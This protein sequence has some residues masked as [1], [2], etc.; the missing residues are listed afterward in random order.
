MANARVVRSS[1]FL[2]KVFYRIDPDPL[3]SSDVDPNYLFK[4][5]SGLYSDDGELFR[6]TDS[7]TQHLY[8]MMMLRAWKRLDEIDPSVKGSILQTKSKSENFGLKNIPDF[9]LE[10]TN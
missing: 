2:V 6:E 1:F 3:G 9:I 7:V 5:I 4:N 10:N 8:S